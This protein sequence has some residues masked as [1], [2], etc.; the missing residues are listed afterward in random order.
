MLR[1][2]MGNNGS[3]GGRD[4]SDKPSVLKFFRFKFFLNQQ[5]REIYR[6]VRRTK[7]QLVVH[8]LVLIFKQVH[9]INGPNKAIK[10]MLRLVKRSISW[11]SRFRFKFLDPFPF[12]MEPTKPSKWSSDWSNE[13]SVGGPGSGSNFWT[14]SHFTW[15]QRSH[16]NDAQIGQTKLQFQ[17]HFL[18]LIFGPVPI[19]NGP[20]EAIKMKHRSV[21]R[22]LV[23]G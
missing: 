20:N 6:Y 5:S 19:K 7:D 1:R 23:W 10:M 16:Q 3:T 17:V 12:Y 8:I 13:A 14:R 2:A 15:N 9:K 11:R 18:V 22:R 4:S 21:R